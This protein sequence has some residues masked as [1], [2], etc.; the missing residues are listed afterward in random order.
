MSEVN[1]EIKLREELRQIL[2][3]NKCEKIIGEVF[4]ILNTICDMRSGIE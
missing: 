4:S 2:I 1:K 3:D